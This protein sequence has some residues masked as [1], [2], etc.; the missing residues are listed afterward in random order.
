MVRRIECE[1]AAV[2]TDG[3]LDFDFALVE[4]MSG[5][6]GGGRSDALEAG[7]RAWRHPA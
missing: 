6:V 7:R 1:Q 5:L 3:G 4:R 2:H